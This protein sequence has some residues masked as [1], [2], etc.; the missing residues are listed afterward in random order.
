MFSLANPPSSPLAGHA[1]MPPLGTSTTSN[2]RLMGGGMVGAPVANIR[3][4]SIADEPVAVHSGGQKGYRT[5]SRAAS[6]TSIGS[7]GY[8]PNP[9]SSPL[10]PNAPY[11]YSFSSPTRLPDHESTAAWKEMGKVVLEE[12]GKGPRGGWWVEVGSG[13]WVL[14][15]WVSKSVGLCFDNAN[16]FLRSRPVYKIRHIQP[17]LPRT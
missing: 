2:S 8:N 11:S 5:V 17:R 16:H 9:P 12:G 15:C 13:G 6:Q 10:A 1:A 4:P 7:A 3:R 14:R